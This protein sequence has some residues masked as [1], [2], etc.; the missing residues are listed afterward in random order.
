MFL[1]KQIG[2]GWNR[3]PAPFIWGTDGKRRQV[4]SLLE[5]S[6]QSACWAICLDPF[7]EPCLFWNP[8]GQHSPRSFWKNLALRRGSANIFENSS[9][10]SARTFT[11]SFPL[12]EIHR[13]VIKALRIPAQTYL[14]CLNWHFPDVSGH[15]CFCGVLLLHGKKNA[16]NPVPGASTGQR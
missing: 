4:C 5:K 14:T 16:W 1:I 11:C 7:S 13:G 10:G 8:W 9:V 2:R 6:G 3:K 12:T 15:Q